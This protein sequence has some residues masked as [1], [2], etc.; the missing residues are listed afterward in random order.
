MVTGVAPMYGSPHVGFLTSPEMPRS[1]VVQE[2]VAS[3]GAAERRSHAALASG[4]HLRL[5]FA[6]AAC[7]GHDKPM[8]GEEVG[9]W[10]WDESLGIIV[11][12]SILDAHVLL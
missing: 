1:P 12:M 8:G 3:P 11:Q 7:A 5:L 9:S 4:C 10:T 2:H 6:A